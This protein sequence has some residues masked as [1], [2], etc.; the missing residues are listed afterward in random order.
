M[1]KKCIGF[2]LL[3]S[4]LFSLFPVYSE[5]AEPYKDDEFPDIF[6][7]IRRAEIITL[8]A[9]PFITFN[10]TLGYS[11]GKYAAHNFDSDYFVNPFSSTDDNG[12]STDEQIGIILTSIGISCGIGITDFIVHAVKRNKK[13][14][15]IKNQK[16][17][18]IQIN[19]IEEDSNATKIERP[20][21]PNELDV[22]E[23]NQ[24]EVQNEDQT[25]IQNENNTEEQITSSKKS[26]KI[27]KVKTGKKI[28]TISEE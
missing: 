17:T 7:D 28:E 25:E 9:M 6:K 12:Y 23:E 14:R 18:E 22:P 16:N 4:L 21:V 1:K 2:V 20:N 15:K 3:F 8:G 19:P 10:V 5:T 11:F 24:N 26:K 27:K 13:M